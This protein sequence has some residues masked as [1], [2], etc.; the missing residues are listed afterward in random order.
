MS[1]ADDRVVVTHTYWHPYGLSKVRTQRAVDRV[2]S[3]TA[4]EVFRKV[5]WHVTGI[6]RIA[7]EMMEEMGYSEEEVRAGVAELLTVGELVEVRGDQITYF[8][9][10]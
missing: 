9:A 10:E 5:S 6:W 4:A 7:E 8:R 1:E 2:V 3:K